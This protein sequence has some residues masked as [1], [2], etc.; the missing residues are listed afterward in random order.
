LNL[1]RLA[2]LT[3]D[4]AL[5]ERG[6]RAIAAFR[7]RWEEAP[8]ALPQLLC[9]FE[10]ALE[11]PR[12][13]VLTG[14][15]GSP[16]FEALAAVLQAKLGPRRTVIALDAPG[17]REWFSRTSPWL[18]QMGEHDAVPTAYVCEE[19]TCRAPARTPAELERALGTPATS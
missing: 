5:R 8:Q 6:R 19:F 17:A 13:V 1:F 10:S 12:H 15:P 4:G 7:G 11:A 9:A 18:R 16:A 3:G 14:A 2:S